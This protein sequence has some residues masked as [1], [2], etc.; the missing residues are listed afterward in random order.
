MH[1][2]RTFAT[3]ALMSALVGLPL[4]A[5]W[6]VAEKID[7]DV[8]YR[9]KEEGLQRS[10]AMELERYLTDVYGPRLT[11]PMRDVGAHFGAPGRRSTDGE[12]AELSH[13][14]SPG[15]RGRG[16]FQANPELNRRRMQ[17]FIAEGV[18]GLVDFSGGDG[19]TVFVKRPQGVSRDPKEPLQAPQVT[20]AVEHYG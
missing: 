15:G 3:A 9:I 6:P 20:I 14:P 17:F 2:R 8:V 13:Q 12:L 1:I 18:A 19:G 10:K 7:L 4:A 5:D 11:T 16:N